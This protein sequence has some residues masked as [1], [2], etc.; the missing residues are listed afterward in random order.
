MQRL[1]IILLLVGLLLC[2]CVI[3]PSTPTVEPTLEPTI[4][5]EAPTDSATEPTKPETTIP[6]ETE[7][8]ISVFDFPTQKFTYT[9]FDNV[10]D[11][12]QERLRLEKYATAF[13]R[14]CASYVSQLEWNDAEGWEFLEN[15]LKPEQ[16]YLLLLQEQYLRDYRA[17]EY[18]VTT[19]ARTAY[20][21]FVRDK[22]C[23]KK[24]ST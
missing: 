13:M 23:V 17:F 18:P 4:S 8:E 6:I 20:E 9:K 5:T 3:S 11:L 14:A 16:E 15:V 12:L 10:E 21:Y 1:F 22:G 2:G 7:P 19:C 24:F